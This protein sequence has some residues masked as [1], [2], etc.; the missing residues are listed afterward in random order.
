MTPTSSENRLRICI[1]CGRGKYPI[2]GMS[3]ADSAEHIFGVIW[4]I[5]RAP[6]TL[7]VPKP[8]LVLSFTKSLRCL[9]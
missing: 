2:L 6:I 1:V 9:F 5:M 7:A 3:M 8:V 4:G